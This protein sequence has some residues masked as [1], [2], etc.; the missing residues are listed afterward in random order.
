MQTSPLSSSAPSA[1]SGPSLPA[2]VIEDASK[3]YGSVQALN[4]IRLEL[5]RG[6]LTALLGPNGAGK[7][8]LINLMLGLE[9][10]T[11]GRVSV[12]GGDPRDPRTRTRLGAMPQDLSLP[13]ALTVHELLTLYAALYPAPL[14][15]PDVLALCDLKAQ[16]R[17]RAA[18]LS[19]GQ[20]RRLGFGLS[21]I[22]DPALLFLDEPTVAM[23][24]QSRQ[25]FWEGVG[26]MQRQGKTIVLTTHYLEEAERSAARIVL[27][28]GG[29]IVADG[30]PQ[31]I[32]AGVQGATIRFVSD[33]VLS[34]LQNLPHVLQATVDDAGRAT[35]RSREPEA[36]LAALFAQGT[37]IHE[38][39]VSRATLEEAFLNLTAPRTHQEMTA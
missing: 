25:I 17:Q 35:L 1:A 16:A 7:S 11:Q 3:R 13:Q 24:V 37:D 15:V 38:L 31:Q 21:I 2:V 39:E 29:R 36:L 22:G 8:T 34:E 5:R 20:A 6:E 18:T 30:T 10:P 33:L 27:L 14:A 19:G 12:M 23:D 28:S 4:S 26:Q 9:A 32:K